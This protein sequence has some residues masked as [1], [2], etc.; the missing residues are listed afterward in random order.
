MDVS[1]AGF[2]KAGEILLAGDDMYFR[3]GQVFA[4]AC[5]S[6]PVNRQVTGDTGGDDLHGLLMQQN[7]LRR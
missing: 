4:E 1:T 7:R 2:S 6:D 5:D 3:S